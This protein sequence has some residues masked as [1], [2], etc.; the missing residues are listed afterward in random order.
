ME[1]GER[2]KSTEM[3]LTMK[4]DGMSWET[5]AYRLEPGRDSRIEV[6]EDCN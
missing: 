5:I 3:A 2:R 4:A 1:E 6:I